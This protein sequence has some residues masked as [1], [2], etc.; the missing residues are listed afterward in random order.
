MIVKNEESVILRCLESCVDVID[1]YCI[2]DT[3]STDFTKKVIKDFFDSKGISGEIHDH[4]FIDFADARNFAI[5]KAKDKADFC[6]TIDADEVLTLPKGFRKETVKQELQKHDLGFIDVHYGGTVYGRRAFFRNSKPFYYFGVV[7]EILLCDEENSGTQVK[8]LY[9]TPKTDGASWNQSQ[10]D[11]Y[12]GH[13]KLFLDY[14]E[15]HP[16]E[17]RSVFYAAQSFKDA[18]ENEKAIEWYG[19]RVA[20]TTGFFE[21]R[22]WSQFMIGYLKWTLSKPVAEVAH[23]F[24]LCCEL[25]PLRAEHLFNL[26]MMYERNGMPESAKLIEGMRK[27]YI[28][29][30]PYPNRVLF[31]QP[32]AYE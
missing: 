14:L 17:P 20:L 25:D 3:G 27:K 7:H 13:A 8:E 26:R 18:G 12:L 21:E 24:M 10:K 28:G 9:V 16:D 11:K 31:I 22:Y 6:F 19:K 30:N 1:N 5:A 29:K 23:A 4:P 32:H 2:T 15:K